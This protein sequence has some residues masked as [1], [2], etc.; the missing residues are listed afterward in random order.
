ME[1]KSGLGKML[2]RI[3]EGFIEY[4]EIDKKRKEFSRRVKLEVVGFFLLMT[5]L[6]FL[7]IGV[8]TFLSRYVPSFLS[9]IIIG[10][11]L[12]LFGIILILMGK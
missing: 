8:I 6:L 10:V 2:D 4:K 11:F 7:L 9:W 12:L 5:G 3:F 1:K